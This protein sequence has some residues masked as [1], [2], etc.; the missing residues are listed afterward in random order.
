MPAARPS[1]MSMRLKALVTPATQKA[2]RVRFAQ[3]GS[4]SRSMTTPAF[5]SASTASNCPRNFAQG[6][7][8]ARSS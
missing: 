7:I 5:N 6:G 2:V 3:W 8:P 4:P 1:M